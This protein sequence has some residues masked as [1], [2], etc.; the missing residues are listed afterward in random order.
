VA[1]QRFRLGGALPCHYGY[2]GEG[3]FGSEVSQAWD[4]ML[5]R[6][7]QYVVVVDPAKYSIPPQVFNQA[8]SRENFPV[9]LRNLETS[10]LF[11]QEPPL[12]ENP[13]IL[14]FRRIQEAPT[15]F[16]RIN[17]GRALSDRGL[18]EQA[19]A[20][21]RE[22]TVL[23]P[24]NVEAWANLALAYERAGRFQEALSAGVRARQLS[25]RHY[26]VNLLLARVS[27]QL[28][29]W[30]DV[31]SYAREAASDAPSATDQVNAW[32]LAARGA[33]QSG[34]SQSG[35]EFLRRAGLATSD[36]RVP[37]APKH[38]CDK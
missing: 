10:A 16:D 4:S 21:L 5:A 36:A 23:G 17:R 9:V 3:F 32:V 35:C 6:R 8:L 24:S 20:E 13:G 7:T 31:V 29:E 34:D 28:E 37:E 2:F 1:K 27:F 33:F 38:S 11:A 25:P 26:Y 30:R 15:P 22:A 19:L 12:V 14:I 18:H